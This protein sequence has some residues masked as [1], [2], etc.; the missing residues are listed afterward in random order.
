MAKEQVLQSTQEEQAEQTTAQQSPQNG[1]TNSEQ[2]EKIKQAEFIANYENALGTLLGGKIYGAVSKELSMSNMTKHA[3]SIVNSLLKLGVDQLD[4]LTEGEIPKTAKDALSKELG[5]LLEPYVQEFMES[6]TGKNLL[7][8]LQDFVGANPYAVAGLGI[9]AAVAAIIADADIPTLKGQFNLGKGFKG[10]IETKL[11]SLR[12]I[13]LGATTLGLEHQKGML[14]SAVSVSRSE[15]GEYS[16][17]ITE[18]FGTK[19][20]FIKG[21]LSMNEEGI[22]AYGLEGLYTFG[23]KT[24]V[25]GKASGTS[26]EE[27]PNLELQIQTA[28][29]GF[30]HQGKLAFQGSTGRLDASYSGKN[31]QLQYGLS[32]ASDTRKGEYLGSS[33]NLKYTPQKGDVYS[34][35]YTHNMDEQGGKH[36]LDLLAQKRMGDF[37][38]RGTQ[39]LDYS[40]SN[41]FK[42][43]TGMMGAYHM[44]NDLALLGGGEYTYNDEMS[45]QN[46]NPHSYKAQLGVQY[47]DVPM[48]FSYD[49]VTKSGSIG[50]TLRF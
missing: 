43:T 14:T 50:M 34:A 18:T 32:L 48:V 35:N 8:I 47:K 12:N 25:R 15:D 21:S 40:R 30:T 44:N 46:R 10:S 16:G 22:S 28:S 3:Q 27:V 6:E 49:P 38:I 1:P 11:G 29:G 20:K 2:Q 37:S 45:A 33:A 7:R 13:A 4:G 17:S 26:F 41:G 5:K 9:L 23:D 42:T 39:N 24:S 19:E 36:H 31:E